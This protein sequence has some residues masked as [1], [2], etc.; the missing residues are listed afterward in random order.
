M[1]LFFGKKGMIESMMGWIILILV[2][3]VILVIAYI[4]FNG[5]NTA[6][7]QF[8]RNLFRLRDIA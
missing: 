1:G 3:F 8:I 6:A 7:G 5:T 2:I 4:S